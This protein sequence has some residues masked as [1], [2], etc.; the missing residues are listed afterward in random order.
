MRL[1]P[2]L[3]SLALI[4]SAMGQNNLPPTETLISRDGIGPARIGESVGE[5]QA[6]LKKINEYL[7]YEFVE[8]MGDGYSGV[9]VSSEGTE[10]LAVYIEPLEKLDP[11]AIIEMVSTDHPAFRFASGVGPGM[12]LSEVEE[13][14]GK[15]S[16]EAAEMDWGAEHLTFEDEDVLAR[17]LIWT[18]S[19]AI[20][21]WSDAGVY[22]KEELEEPYRSTEKYKPM[23][24]VRG[25]L[26]SDWPE[27]LVFE[28]PKPEK[29]G[30]YVVSDVGQL[31]AT[32]A[33]GRTIFLE[34]V[35]FHLTEAWGLFENEY[36][37]WTEEGALRIVGVKDLK[38]VG[39][40]DNPESASVLAS[41]ANE[42]VIHFQEC[43]NIML[44]N[45]ILGHEPEE[46]AC[47]AAVIGAS[48]TSRLEIS[49]CDLFGCGSHGLQL[50]DCFE[51]QVNQSVIRDCTGLLSAFRNSQDVVFRNTDFIRNKDEKYGTGLVIDSC[52]DIRFEGC[53][54]SEN[55]MTSTLF[56]VSGASWNIRVI[57]CEI[58]D[59]KMTAVSDHAVVEF[60]NT[61]IDGKNVNGVIG[62]VA[63][64]EDVHA[65]WQRRGGENS[66][67][68]HAGGRQPILL[69]SSDG[70]GKI[71]SDFEPPIAWSAD[72]QFLAL[73]AGARRSGEVA[74]FRVE[75]SILEPITL[76]TEMS[77]AE[78]FGD[79][80]HDYRAEGV[81][82][83]QWRGNQLDL[84]VW[85]S[86]ADGT[87]AWRMVFE[88]RGESAKFVNKFKLEVWPY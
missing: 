24:Y 80:P 72:K 51:V 36:I 64:N 12:L 45:L 85:R 41:P 52:S 13:R 50:D 15:F 37:Q 11:D 70:E 69:W 10:L 55:V 74:L 35:E 7:E 81:E 78:F 28:I 5:M 62:A 46:W 79:K 86:G 61:K 18:S 42:E 22:T 21:F 17:A 57:E 77:E 44:A 3:L 67:R 87:T 65:R 8:G 29:D 34:P 26:I 75:G 54:I 60:E 32:I 53:K 4:S 25:I 63:K 20:D 56:Q 84:N 27:E 40:P 76:D 47:Y 73:G 66:L 38:L 71:E 19:P 43:E 30:S 14:H 82:I 83:A 33:P 2:S 16:L 1:L 49:G 23:A 59:N 88:I 9:I 31:L 58:S 68:L 48:Q 6:A 39:P